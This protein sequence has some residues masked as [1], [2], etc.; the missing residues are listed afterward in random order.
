MRIFYTIALAIIMAAPLSA[1]AEGFYASENCQDILNRAS[2]TDRLML[3]AWVIGYLNKQNGNPT[4]VRIDNARTVLGNVTQQCARTPNATLLELVET[5]TRSS[6]DVPGTGAHARVFLSQFLSARAD[7]AELTAA[8]R[9][10][11]AEIRAVYAPPLADR[12]IG[13][14]AQLF[15]PGAAIG[16][17]PG[18][19]EV[20][21]WGSTT[22]DL[23]AGAPILSEFP[24]GYKEV[25]GAM[26][27][28]FPIFRF[29]FVKPGERSGMAF[30]G[31]IYINNRYV[32]M[33]KPWR[34]LE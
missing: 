26:Q 2:D 21:L 15:Q 8:M 6:P 19:T 13:H 30:D 5:S 22:S 28:N 29:K 7:R 32:L 34:V 24:G 14:Y 25:R 27:G 17:N 23:R 10:T 18:Q 11:E 16:P 1:R 33:P 31:L 9:P 3:A 20:L 12:L 4:L